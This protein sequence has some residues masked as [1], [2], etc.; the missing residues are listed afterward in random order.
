MNPFSSNF[1]PEFAE[2]LTSALLHFVWQGAVLTLI[3][4]V[5]VK[6]LD[7]R[8]ARLRYLLS[9]GTL[10]MMAV[11]PIATAALHHQA[12]SQPRHSPVGMSGRSG[13]TIA[14]SGAMN[15]NPT[16]H[17]ATDL[18]EGPVTSLDPSIEVYVL[19]AWLAGVLILSTRL[20]IGFGVTLWIRVKTT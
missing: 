1:L 15:V 4:L 8:T 16:G 14:A 10:L 6:L 19:T 5:T 7:V 18:Q 13:S 20:A 3:L 2:L 9:V 12:N 17:F 11:A